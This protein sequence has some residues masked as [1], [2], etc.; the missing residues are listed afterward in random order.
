MRKGRGTGPAVYSCR[1]STIRVSYV[2]GRARVNAP[3]GK[4]S[5]EYNNGELSAS[6]ARDRSRVSRAALAVGGLVGAG[7]LVASEFTRVIE[8]TLDGVVVDHATG[9]DQHSGALFVLAA[10]AVLFSILGPGMGRGAATVALGAVGTAVLVIALAF[11]LPDATRTGTLPGSLEIGEA[12]PAI[13]FYLELAGGVLLLAIAATAL[14]L[15]R[16]R[17]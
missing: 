13:G 12:R 2:P 1:R 11:D 8:V 9:L 16:S 4:T 5:R 15:A 17:S 3:R 14:L 7:L 6:V 10:A